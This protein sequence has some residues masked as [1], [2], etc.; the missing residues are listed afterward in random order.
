MFKYNF[1]KNGMMLISI[2]MLTFLLVMLTTAII[3]ISS[4]QLNLTGR[5]E[6]RIQALQAAEAGVE[7]ALYRLNSEPNWSPNSDTTEI[8]NSRQE[9]TI[10]SFDPLV[11][12]HSTNNLKNPSSSGSTPAF[13]AEIRCQ[14]MFKHGTETVDVFM[15]AI[16]VRDDKVPYS[17]CSGG[18]LIL[19]GRNYSTTPGVSS[20]EIKGKNT[21]FLGRA[22]A[23]S[24]IEIWRQ[25]HDPVELINLLD[26]FM[27]SSGT[28]KSTWPSYNLSGIKRKENTVPAKLPLISINDIVDAGSSDPSFHKVNQPNRIYLIGYFEYA[29]GICIPHNTPGPR[30]GDRDRFGNSSGPPYQKGIALI[31]ES[32]FKTFLNNYGNCYYNPSPNDSNGNT[33]L[34]SLYPTLTFWDYDDPNF[35][36]QLDSELKMGMNYD[37]S[38]PNHRLF[39]L[40]LQEN[41]FIEEQTYM[42]MTESMAPS[43][44]DPAY[45][46]HQMV[47]TGAGLDLNSHSIYAEK[48]VCI[49]I[50]LSGEGNI[51]SKETLDFNIYY[52]ADLL[53]LSE[54]SVRAVYH[55]YAAPCSPPYP[56]TIW[57]RFTLKGIFYSKDNLI[58][59]PNVSSFKK[60][61]IKG[62]LI[63]LDE[64]TNNME[65]S[66]LAYR[67]DMFY[68]SNFGMWIYSGLYGDNDYM[69]IE[70]S[71]DGLAELAGLRGDDFQVRKM[72]CE[73]IR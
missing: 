23:N 52:D 25:H 61:E 9:F 3:V 19:V 55:G 6:K 40:T 1:S 27:S 46:L 50:P 64:Q 47:N 42:F 11:P 15:R 44:L 45:S 31:Q 32:S 51:I 38:D 17:I 62:A 70:H 59:H 12:N 13:S 73:E 49:G 2:L 68:N 5:L 34:Y 37:D 53:V 69:I 30:A 36:T 43:G 14:G 29:P 57:E 7:Y 18:P 28:I 67:T 20:F 39:N 10:I 60:P 58:I 54:K 35:P 66:I 41:L 48:P 4:E 63:C 21:G 8:I 22:H 26:G 71:E 72:F 33:N 56:P 16:F 24:D 65:P